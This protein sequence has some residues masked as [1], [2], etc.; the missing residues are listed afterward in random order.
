[1]AFPGAVTGPAYPFPVAGGPGIAVV[2]LVPLGAVGLGTLVVV[3]PEG[4][5]AGG[6]GLEV[7]GVDAGAVSAAV[8][9]LHA[10][11]YGFEVVMFPGDAVGCPFW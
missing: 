4:V 3:L 5:F 11:W 6:D 7:L 10:F 9:E 2:V 8:I 1:M